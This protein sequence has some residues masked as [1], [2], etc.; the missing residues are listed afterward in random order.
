VYKIFPFLGLAA[1]GL[2]IAPM[3]GSVSAHQRLSTA[4]DVGVMIHLDPNDLPY[5]KKPTKTWFMLMRRNGAMI[6]PA[7]CN[8]SVAAYDSR[9]RAIVSNLPLSTIPVEGHQKGHEAISTTITFPKAGA[10][11]VVLAGQ[12]KDKS[13]APFELKFP[14]T[15]RP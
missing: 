7:S 13:F 10:Y 15:V 4:G 5:P 8:C 9:N 2:V 11:T 1:F 12:A 3:I 6:S 14:V